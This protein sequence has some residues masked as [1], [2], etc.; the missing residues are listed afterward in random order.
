MGAGIAQY[1]A[2]LQTEQSG[3]LGSI[4]NNFSCSLCVQ[5]ISE[6]H[7]ACYPVRTGGPFPGVKRGRGVT[8]TTHPLDFRGQKWV[9]AIYLLLP[10]SPAWRYRDSCTFTYRSIIAYRGCDWYLS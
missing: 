8:Q 9:G 7:P 6:A 3:D 2:W 10:L 5:T 1:I 4:V